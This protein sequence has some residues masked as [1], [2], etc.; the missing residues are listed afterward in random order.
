MMTLSRPI[1]RYHAYL[2]I[3]LHP[4]TLRAPSV[5]PPRIPHR[6]FHA[7]HSTMPASKQALPTPRSTLLSSV[8]PASQTPTPSHGD[9]L[10][11]SSS[12]AALPSVGTPAR[13]QSLPCNPA[14]KNHLS[15]KFCQNALRRQTMLLGCRW[16]FQPPRPSGDTIIVRSSLMEDLIEYLRQQI[17]AFGRLGQTLGDTL[18]NTIRAA[19]GFAVAGLFLL[20]IFGLVWESI[21]GELIVEKKQDFCGRCGKGMLLDGWYWRDDLP[22]DAPLRDCKKVCYSCARVLMKE[23]HFLAEVGLADGKS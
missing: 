1:V 18:W 21:F 6:A 5:R 16:A 4:S 17:Y 20:C 13:L 9:E 2:N 3:F 12:H 22:P 14:S 23:G 8:R 15:F 10:S 19:L 7:A 11:I